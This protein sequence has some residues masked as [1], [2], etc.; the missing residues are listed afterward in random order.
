MAKTYAGLVLCLAAAACGSG[1]GT[2]GVGGGVGNSVPYDQ[3]TN[4]SYKVICAHYATCGI[5]RSETSCT[6]YYETLLGA[7]ATSAATSYYDDAIKAGKI[8]YDGAAAARCLNGYANASC[9]LAALLAPSNDCAS[10]YVGQVQVGS[11]CR[12][13]QCV[14]S[15]Y[16]SA[17]VDKVCPGTCKARVQAGGTATS[18]VECAAGLVLISGTCSQPP[19]EGAGCAPVSGTPALCAPGLVCAADTKKCTKPRVSSA[20]CSA[21]EPCDTF[22]R[23]VNGTCTP[24]G[25]VGDD[26][27]TSTSG[28]SCKLELY[29]KGTGTTRV[30]A[31][32]LGEGGSCTTGSDCLP[33]LRC[34]LTAPGAMTSTCQKPIAK[35]GACSTGTASDCETGTYCHG[36][37]MT[38]VPELADGATCTPNDRCNLG[39]CTGGKCVSYLSSICL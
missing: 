6:Q 24:P 29:C 20:T 33:T 13:G 1:G 10:I 3:Y 22:Y 31:E 19:G 7:Y 2:G 11:A 27:A 14:P 34:R 12:F 17:D 8:A 39:T 9:S 21:T 23:C 32:R 28:L 35:N 25:D 16:C 15:A 37:S 30:C 38:C 18:G 36:T 4:Q 5:A 26:C